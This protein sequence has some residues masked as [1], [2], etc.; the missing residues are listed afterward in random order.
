MRE[1]G[2]TREGSARVDA[3]L[4]ARATRKICSWDKKMAEKEGIEHRAHFHVSTGVERITESVDWFD[5]W[6][7][8]EYI[9]IAANR[10]FSAWKCVFFWWD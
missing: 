6:W 3:A 7:P 9:I 2:G 8:E 10:S 5:W 4:K 1:E